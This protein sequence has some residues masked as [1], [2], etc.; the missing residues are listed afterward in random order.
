MLGRGVAAELGLAQPGGTARDG[1]ERPGERRVGNRREAVAPPEHLPDQARDDLVRLPEGDALGA[2]E[3]VGQLRRRD[4]A[5]LD[6]PAHAR[7]VDAR[8]PDEPGE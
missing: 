5:L 7:L 8:R 1:G 6:V 4:A 3:R 2:D